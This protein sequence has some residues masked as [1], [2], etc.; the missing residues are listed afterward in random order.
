MDILLILI[1]VVVALPIVVYVV[2]HRDTGRERDLEQLA[3]ELDMHWHK[4][5]GHQ[6]ALPAEYHY[7][8]TSGDIRYGE[9]LQGRHRDRLTEIVEVLR[10]QQPGVDA[11]LPARMAAPST[12]HGSQWRLVGLCGT[13]LDDRL[14][15]FDLRMRPVAAW[16]NSP[17]DE[18]K[19]AGAPSYW[20]LTSPEP[21]DVRALLPASVFRFWSR[22]G[23]RVQAIGGQLICTLP[24]RPWHH[25]RLNARNV[26]LMLK[27]LDWESVA[28]R[29]D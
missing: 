7:R 11:L 14:P 13:H 18:L 16:R 25:A 5:T 3:T 12:H 26:R 1:V 28:G 23:C 19:N 8:P 21:E 6:V 22:H 20:L 24:E 29:P 17:A 15:D 27:L 2:S 10:P 4:H 9:L